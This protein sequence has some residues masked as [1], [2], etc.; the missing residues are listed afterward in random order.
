M[1]V[2]GGTAKGRLLKAVVG[3][4]PTAARVRA[5]LFSALEA[6][7][8][9]VDRVLDLYAGSGAL[10]IEALSRGASWCDF[11]EQD[12]RACAQIRRNL[13]ATGLAGRAS[14][15]CSSV[16]RALGRLRGPYS[17]ILA[18]PP[19]RDERALETLA[20]LA[21]SA[22]VVVGLTTIVIEHRS[23]Q[24]MPS[25]MGPFRLVKTLRHG[26]S[27]LSFYR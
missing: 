22:L 25:A 26:D 9:S 12:R 7:G 18:D 15:I 23:S 20:Q 6:M 3:T 10:G 8:A 13:V 4:R 16:E 5:A 11:V 19:Y 2:L 24:P 1:R 17:L 27:A 21:S 14:V